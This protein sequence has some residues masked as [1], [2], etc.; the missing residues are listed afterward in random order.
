MLYR[1]MEEIPLSVFLC[2]FNFFSKL[3]ANFVKR[4]FDYGDSNCRG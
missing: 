1:P 3:Y 4:V 2:R